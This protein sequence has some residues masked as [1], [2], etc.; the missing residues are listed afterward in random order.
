M[1][2]KRTFHLIAFISVFTRS[3]F[4]R[5]W[6]VQELMLAKHVKVYLGVHEIPLNY[7][8]NSLR[9]LDASMVEKLAQLNFGILTPFLRIDFESSTR[10]FEARDALQSSQLG[11]LEE[12]LALGRG[13][14]AKDAK[15]KVYSLLSI[16]YRESLGES[17]HQGDSRRIIA[18]YSKSTAQVYTECARYL[19]DC[20]NKLTLLSSVGSCEPVVQDLPSWV[21]DLSVPL[22]PRPLR[23]CG[24]KASGVITNV[25]ADFSVEGKELNVAAAQWDTVS[26]TGE[27]L[28]E[29]SGGKGHSNL[30][31]TLK[32][33]MFRII[34]Q[35][36]TTYAPTQEGMMLVVF[37]TLIGDIVDSP[38]PSSPEF[39]KAF[40]HCLVLTGLGITEFQT[41][42]PMRIMI[43]KS[44]GHIRA[45]FDDFITMYD[46]PSYPFRAVREDY[47]RTKGGKFGRS[48]KYFNMG[49]NPHLRESLWYASAVV[50]AASDRCLFITKKGYLGLGPWNMKEEDVVFLVPGADAPIVLRPAEDKWKL[51]GEAYVHGIMHGEAKDLSF[52]SIKII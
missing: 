27:S 49:F 5:V 26:A 36:G 7:L 33:N 8:L 16:P 22:K 1:A 48:S 14:L 10:I 12:Y 23:L 29:A 52:I 20:D 3:W 37:R 30:M 24:P 31:S 34:M 15:D 39:A 32:G 21:P 50:T 18:D 43:G 19:L 2:Q 17:P 4:H 45:A 47:L 41:M 35:L 44:P 9:L 25:K 13:R 40:T 6:I 11:T 51:V 46:G 28:N 38:K 42:I